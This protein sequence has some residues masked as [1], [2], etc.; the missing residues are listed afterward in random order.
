MTNPV[1]SYLRSNL[2]LSGAWISVF[3]A[4]VIAYWPG[5]AGPWLFDD[6]D[7]LSALGD[8][9]GVRDWE[10]FKAFVLGGTAGP[11][12]R[13]LAL[14]SFLIDGQ[15]W[16]TEAW[17]F[18][19]TNVV[20][21]LLNGALLGLLI[22]KILAALRFERQKA[23]AIILIAVAAWLLHPYL[24]STTLYIVQRMAQ[25]STM[26]ILAGLV[27]YMHG[28]MQIEARPKAAYVV[29]TA[30]LA[31]FGLLALLA[32]ENGILLPVLTLVLEITVLAAAAAPK[33]NRYWSTIFLIMPFAVILLYLA[34]RVLDERFFEI[35]PP[36]D[37]SI[38][39]RLLTQSRVLVDYLQNW[40]IPKLY[41][42]GVFQDH[43]TKSTGLLAPVS[44]LIS[45]VFHVVVI[46]FA[47]ATRRRWPLVSLAVLFF[48]AGHLVESTVI[49]LELYFEH[50][51]YLPAAF[52][53]LPGVV[54]LG[55]KLD[56]KRFI[57]VATLVLA[58]LGGFTRY[59]ATVWQ[60]FELM[61]AT[62]ARKA[63]SSA[64]AQAH[65]SANLFNAGRIDEAFEVLDRALDND[66]TRK[67]LLVIQ[68]LILS[69]HT[70]RLDLQQFERDAGIVSTSPYDAR[71]IAMYRELTDAIVKG[72]CPAVPGEALRSMF[73][74]ML[75]TPPNDDPVSMHFSQ[76]QYFIGY[77]S[78]HLNEPAAAVDAFKAS[79][80]SRPDPSSAM[81]MAAV[82]ATNRHRTEALYLSD[83]A[84]EILSR[85]DERST[86]RT[87]VTKADITQFQET[88]HADDV[89]LQ[90]GGDTPGPTE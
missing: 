66:D 30:S 22:S 2:A 35:L 10:T 11:T 13:P 39:E 73:K 76:I 53:F 44:T 16:P 72:N 21:H 8:F 67:P 6:F 81:A 85:D 4:V 65:H 32:K 12:G 56:T 63:P 24:V 47:V 3:F 84:L 38:Y 29:M 87:N 54:F 27:G 43:F 31:G 17:P 51:N 71:M 28:R 42:T 1:Q 88:V 19:R 9:G 77:I 25:L 83:L 48:Y 37:F 46:G 34:N 86:R 36:R 18:K 7:S 79:L 61:A 49:N 33:L 82:L 78:A 74:N 60:S 90:P 55:Q 69:C 20:I 15:D 52:L 62:S 64:R 80:D 75:Q 41:T 23:Q 89:A 45:A 5:L 70:Q 59:S 68:R 58:M 14:L 57:F 26:F 50:R 40:F